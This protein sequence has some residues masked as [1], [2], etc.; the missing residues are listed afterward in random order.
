MKKLKLCSVILTLS[1]LFT[2]TLTA[3]AVA[4][5]AYSIG[6]EFHG[7]QDVISAADY[8]ALCGYASYYTTEPTYSYVS[9]SDRLNSD[10]LYFSS[11]G[12]RYS[13]ALP[14]NLYLTCNWNNGSNQVGIRSYSLTNTRLVVYDA[15]S[16]AEGND[17]LCTYTI[18]QGAD[19]VIGWR[20]S[21][22]ASDALKWQKRFQEY[23]SR[24]YKVHQAMDYADSFSDYSDN[25]TIKNHL[26]YGDW[27]QVIKKSRAALSNHAEDIS[28]VHQI[29]PIEMEFGSDISSVTSAV[30][31]AFPQFQ[32]DNYD[33]TITS[34]SQD[35]TWFVVDLTEKMGDF[36]TSSGF[37][38]VFRDN[39]CDTIYDNT[40]YTPLTRSAPRSFSEQE[41]EA[42][43][44]AAIQQAQQ[45]LA[46]RND[47]SVITE[48]TGKLYYDKATDQYYYQVTTVYAYQNTEATGAFATR[49]PM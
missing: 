42:A 4:G 16:T 28:R 8:W 21:I 25:S 22:L 46:A 48:Q 2:P 18:S 19:A 12:S 9:S 30:K 38:L 47:Q 13:L 40:I 34:T 29:A 33:I 3:D 39:R 20:V 49:Y 45:E 35:N 17:N 15:C 7:G 44:A 24:G 23:C 37:T 36:T 6:G 27:L 1:L 5:R 11:H 32:P 31:Q 10:I 41:I 43:R 14:N 26:I